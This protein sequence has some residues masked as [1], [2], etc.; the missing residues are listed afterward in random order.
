MS[1]D[2]LIL[3]DPLLD[4]AQMLYLTLQNVL[5]LETL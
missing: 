2:I 3:I 5:G 1:R 4:F